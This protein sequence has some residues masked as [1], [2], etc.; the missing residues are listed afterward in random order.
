MIMIRNACRSSTKVAAHPMMSRSNV[1]LI[2]LIIHYSYTWNGFIDINT[3]HC[4]ALGGIRSSL[5]RTSMER[6]AVC[7]HSTPLRHLESALEKQHGDV[8]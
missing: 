2:I 8:R 3:H 4:R 7:D 6:V 1:T 5:R